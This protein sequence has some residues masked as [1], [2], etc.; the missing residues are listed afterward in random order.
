MIDS[1][2][3]AVNQL[4]AVHCIGGYLP[5]R[6]CPFRT[7]SSLVLGRYQLGEMETLLAKQSEPFVMLKVSCCPNDRS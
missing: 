2:N 3:N 4:G 1:A 6:R 5:H 7:V